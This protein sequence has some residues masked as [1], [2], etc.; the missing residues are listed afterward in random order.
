MCKCWNTICNM[1][2]ALV[3]M[4]KVFFLL[5]K[6]VGAIVFVVGFSLFLH[7]FLFSVQLLV[8]FYDSVLV[9]HVFV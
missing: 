2:D 3:R 7:I 4:D 9:T 6:F 8:L 1:Y 5:T